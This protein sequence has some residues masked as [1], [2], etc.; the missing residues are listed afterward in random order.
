MKYHFWSTVVLL[1]LVAGL[2]TGGCNLD[3]ATL[4]AIDQ[5]VKTASY[6]VSPDGFSLV[7]IAWYEGE[8]W[9]VQWHNGQ[10]VSGGKATSQSIVWM[11]DLLKSSGFK[12]KALTELPKAAQRMLSVGG[13][14]AVYGGLNGLML[15]PV[16]PENFTLQGSMGRLNPVE[17]Q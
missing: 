8:Q 9:V 10:L 6:F 4:A 13:Q 3:P 12:A 2:F 11:Y 17:V 7:G 5:S 14:T 1:L 15:L 16:T